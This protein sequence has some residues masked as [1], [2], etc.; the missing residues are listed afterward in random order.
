[1][2]LFIA[3]GIMNVWAMLG[4]A[5]IVLTEKL[6]RHGQTVGRIAGAAFI[7]LGLGVAL[8]PRIADAVVPPMPS[9]EP[10]MTEMGAAVTPGRP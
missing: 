3:F 1:M 10:A 9:T 5:V 8:S 4:L 2:A 6:S 7:V